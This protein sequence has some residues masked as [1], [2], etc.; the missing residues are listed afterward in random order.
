[1]YVC[2]C[3][4]VTDTAIKQAADNGAKNIRDLKAQLGLGTGC[5]KCMLHALQTLKGSE[6]GAERIAEPSAKA[7]NTIAETN[8][9]AET[10]RRNLRS[11]LYG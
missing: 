6:P 1:M 9:E 11:A 5:G 4:A 3:K 2:V 7:T 10:P 8:V